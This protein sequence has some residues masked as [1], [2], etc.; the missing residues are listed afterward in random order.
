MVATFHTQLKSADHSFQIIG[1]FNDH[2]DPIVF[3]C[4]YDWHREISLVNVGDRVAIG[5]VDY[6]VSRF[7]VDMNGVAVFELE[8][9]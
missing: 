9:S 1:V 4:R 2:S 5:G 6:S 7:D 8:V 3:C